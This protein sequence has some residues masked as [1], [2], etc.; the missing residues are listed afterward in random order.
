MTRQLPSMTYKAIGLTPLNTLISSRWDACE[1]SGGHV[2]ASGRVIF[3]IQPRGMEDVPMKVCDNCGVP[4]FQGRAYSYS[5]NRWWKGP[6][7]DEAA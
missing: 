6:R 2:Y 1:Q 7:E 4:A 5:I 3:R